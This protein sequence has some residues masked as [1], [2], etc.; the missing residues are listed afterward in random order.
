M[1]LRW[2][3]SS[4]CQKNVFLFT[5]IQ[6][7]STATWKIFAKLAAPNQTKLSNHTLE[8]NTEEKWN[9]IF[10]SLRSQ[11]DI[12]EKHRSAV[13]KSRRQCGYSKEVE[14]ELPGRHSLKPAEVWTE[15]KKQ[16]F[17]T[18]CISSLQTGKQLLRKAPNKQKGAPTN[19]VINDTTVK[20]RGRVHPSS[21]SCNA[22]AAQD[23]VGWRGWR[24]QTTLNV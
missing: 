4:C 23:T 1:Q 10:V 19:P 7:H 6:S 17:K 21:S 5:Q 24:Q 18:S 22:P 15:Q 2:V 20:D 12:R 11:H 9:P 14:S 3:S 13:S 16:C 8:I